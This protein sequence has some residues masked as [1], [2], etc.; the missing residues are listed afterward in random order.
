MSRRSKVI[1]H[2]YR[3]V[4]ICICRSF[5]LTDWLSQDLSIDSKSVDEIDPF[6]IRFATSPIVLQRNQ[7]LIC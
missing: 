6:I 2:K 3:T 4:Q 7:T 5:S 1:N